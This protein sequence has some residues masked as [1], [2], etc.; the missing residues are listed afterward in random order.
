VYLNSIFTDDA[1]SALFP[2]IDV[3]W[4]GRYYSCPLDEPHLWK[5][6]R[7]TELNPVRAGFVAKAESWEWSSAAA[8]C[9]LLPIGGYLAMELWQ[10]RWSAG[11]S[12]ARS[13]IDIAAQIFGQLGQ[14]HI[15]LVR[16]APLFWSD[17]MR[18]AG[19]MPLSAQA[20]RTPTVA[21]NPFD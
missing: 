12:E 5:A 15:G 17:K 8:H 13:G 14:P 4:Q 21:R 11:T 18:L 3:W 10:A 7:Y 19:A 2:Q 20:S 1:C 16:A 6:L 9:A